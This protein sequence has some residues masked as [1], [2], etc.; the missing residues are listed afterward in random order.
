MANVTTSI[1]VDFSAG[2]SGGVL[3]AE[4]DSRTLGLNGGKTSFAP[5]QSPAI[6][7]YKSNNVLIDGFD[8]SYP[9]T[10]TS[11]GIQVVEVEEFL[12]FVKTE[13]ATPGKPI[14]SDFTYKWLGNDLGTLVGGEMVVTLTPNL[15]GLEIGLAKVNYKTNAL[16]YRISGVPLSMDGETSFGI[17]IYLAGHS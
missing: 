13:S 8:F 4:V 10:I 14:H 3:T 5:G 17:I 11:L 16:A 2:D 7:V 1:V 12:Q 6:L 9:V 15:S